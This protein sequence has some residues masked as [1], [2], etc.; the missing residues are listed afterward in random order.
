LWP[1]TGPDTRSV[2]VL[3]DPEAQHQ[4]EEGAVPNT[5]SSESVFVGEQDGTPIP[6]DD[7][8]G[9]A[10]AN[11]KLLRASNLP[12]QIRGP[13][14]REPDLTRR[15]KQRQRGWRWV[16]TLVNKELNKVYRHTD[17]K[18]TSIHIHKILKHTIK[19]VHI[20]L[21][22]CKA[23]IATLCQQ[24]AEGKSDVALIQEPWK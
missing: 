3:K 8:R 6:S 24:V 20:N 13:L 7:R 21:H 17:F 1:L 10:D 12:Q 22:Y 15:K 14:R 5:A 16:P 2:K 11:T 23:A 9:A 4:K 18:H 19:F